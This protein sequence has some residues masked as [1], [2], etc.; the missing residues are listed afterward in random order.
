MFL[1]INVWIFELYVEFAD[2]D[3]VHSYDVITTVTVKKKF[4]FRMVYDVVLLDI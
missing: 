1:K 4:K 2:K 3:T